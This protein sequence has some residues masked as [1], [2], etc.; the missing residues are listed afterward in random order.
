MTRD[1]STLQN[2]GN[3]A[4]LV[5]DIQN[6]FCHDGGVF[7]QQGLNVQPAQAVTPRIKA[8]VEAVRAYRV[9]VIY[10][11]QIESDEVSPDNLKQQFA[12][13]KL[14]PVCAPDS[15]GSELY[16]LDPAD[17]EYVLVKHTYDIFSNL[18][19]NELLKNKKVDTVIVT[20]VNTD[21]CIDTT[22]RRAFTEGYKVVV[23]HNLVATMNSEAENHYLKIFNQFFGTV[24]DS[25]NVL[26]YLE[27]AHTST[28]HVE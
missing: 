14:V 24:T 21:V 18:E 7:A 22:V 20:G 2:L 3:I 12:S 1:T 4:V 27:R 23:P 8:F 13:G 26:E 19:L 28:K 25:S 11:K 15:W 10:S 6:D 17:G 5:V 9:P 16:Q